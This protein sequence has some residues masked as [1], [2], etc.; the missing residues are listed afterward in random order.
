MGLLANKYRALQPTFEYLTDKV[1]LAQAWKKAHQYIRS[2]NWYADNF[3]LDRSA[4]DL[5][6]RLD[7]WLADLKS[8]DFSFDDLRLVPAPKA[9][10]WT[11]VKAQNLNILDMDVV[12]WGFDASEVST[13]KWCPEAKTPKPLR[14]LAHVSIRDQSLLMALMMC[15]VNKVESSQ[16]NTATH[17]NEVHQ[18][19]IVNYGNRLYCQ[20]KDSDATFAWGNSTSYSKYFSDYQKFLA[21]PLYFGAEALQQ[22]LKGQHVFEVHLDIAKFYDNIDRNKLASGIRALCDNNLDPI[23]EKLLASFVN[24]KW[25]ATSPAIYEAVCKSDQESIPSGIPQGLVV[26][27][28]LANI[29]LLKFDEIAQTLISQDLSENIHLVDYCRYV[30]DMRLIILVDD[31]I[32]SE[33]IRSVIDEKIGCHLLAL[34]LKFNHDKT[35]IEK[36]RYKRAG[37]STKLKDI[38]SK[39]SGPLSAT[40]VDEQ[41]GHLEGLIGLADSLRA[42]E[43]DQDNTNPLAIIEAP[44]NDVRDDTLLRFS[45]NKIHALLKQKR[46]F[47]SQELDENGNPKPGAWDYLQER[48]ARKF[49]SCWSKDP[50]LTLLL[51]KGLELFPDKRIL[52]PVLGQLTSVAKREAE[53]QQ[54]Q[55]AQYCLGEIFRHAATLIHTKEKW[56]FPAHADVSGFFEHLQNLAVKMI[57]SPST[58]KNL[59]DQAMFYCLVRNDSPLDQDTNSDDFNIITKM[60]KGYRNISAKMSAVDFIANALLSYQLSRDK[61]LVVRAVSCLLEK[62]FVKVFPLPTG[63]LYR[64]DVFRFCK[65]IAVESPEFLF[66][67]ADYAKNNDCGWISECKGVMEK[68][69]LFQLA[70]TGD[71]NRF[72][73]RPISLLGVVKRPDNPFAHENAALA[74]LLALMSGGDFDC[75]LN[76]LTDNTLDLPANIDLGNCK[77]TCSNWGKIQSLDVRFS[78]V[79]GFDED[80][81]FP[82]PEWIEDNHKPLYRLGIFLR[83]CLMGNVDWSSMTPADSSQARYIGLRSSF[84]K[85]QLGMMHSPEALNGETA[86]MSNWVSS[87]LFALLQWP[88]TNLH[89]G[90]YE[91]PKV[92]DIKALQKLTIE[93]LEYQKELFCK[94]TGIPAYVEKLSF[95]WQKD[96]KSLKVVMVQSLLPLKGDFQEHGLMLDTPKY[97]SRHRRHIASVAELI[98]HKAHSQ[99]SI[100]DLNYKDS[101]IDLIIWPEL[102]VSEQDVDILHQLA[103]KTGAIIFTGLTFINLPGVEGPNNVAKWLIP[104]KLSAGKK[105][106]SRLQGKFNMMKD[107]VGKVKPWRPYQLL[108]ELVHPAF[109]KDKGFT[110]SGSVCYDATDIKISADLK[111]KSD[112]YLVVALNQDVTTFD[113]MVDALYYHMYQHVALV[114]TGEFGGSVAKAPYKERHDKLIT[115]VHGSHQVSISSFEM[116]M[117][118]FRNVGASYKSG[119]KVKTKPAG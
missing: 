11:F 103:N 107:E 48:M 102:S 5:D 43:T 118:D 3:E 63:G 112:A 31:G 52:K 77:I 45:A 41:L 51:K 60:M 36:F 18:K 49:I 10:R 20:F 54:Q 69:G 56:T 70:I 85:R 40:E 106:I 88:G 57:S 109:P 87:L 97:R 62:S 9:E 39:V 81:I 61:G 76:S 42:S 22:K 113:S 86:P 37:I 71:L 28:F 116:N 17:L 12:G 79:I 80:P 84:M 119:K 59:L 19:R 115:H 26:G 2:T 83:S 32:R 21:R 108:I 23:V 91:W 96:K 66:A 114:N 44:S 27:G 101:S 73:G 100:D 78:I 72:N 13:H 29:Y 104:Q 94:M 68:A 105:F 15:L 95:G 33:E 34:G 16:G 47:F 99:R 1:V 98:L 58:H 110:L 74:L 65:K 8:P 53:L 14:P 82:L 75:N 67:L 64:A 24:W 89:E 6:E 7:H 93:R 35:K 38:Q 117:F 25:D 55:V 50:S 92:W 46:S 111:D 90:N 30:D 4:I